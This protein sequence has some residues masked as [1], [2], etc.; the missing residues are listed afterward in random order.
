MDTALQNRHPCE[1][2]GTIGPPHTSADGIG[3]PTKVVMTPPHGKYITPDAARLRCR[4]FRLQP[5]PNI[6]TPRSSC[7]RSLDSSLDGSIP[8]AMFKL[9][10][11]CFAIL[12]L[13]C[14]IQCTPTASKRGG[15]SPKPEFLVARGH[16]DFLCP[17]ENVAG[18]ELSKSYTDSGRLYCRYDVEE[19]DDKAY[20]M[21]KRVRLTYGI[22]T[23]SHNAHLPFQLSRTPENCFQALHLRNVTSKQ[24][25]IA[26]A[27]RTAKKI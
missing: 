21:Y 17:Y 11:V 8:P 4:S 20:C 16:C 19:T 10:A 9:F 23:P 7:Y 24:S 15:P 22:T 6:D 26:L 1:D 5:K 25:S 14:T 27:R 13:I 12:S 2:L 18:K 3:V